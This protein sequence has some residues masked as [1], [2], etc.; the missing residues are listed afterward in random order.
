FG[1]TEGDVDIASKVGVQLYAGALTALYTAAATYVVLKL[2]D[3][4]TGLRVSSDEETQG[5]D[6][7][8]HEEVGYRY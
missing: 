7:A 1:G 5:L 6:L 3:A 2:T 4:I 8:L